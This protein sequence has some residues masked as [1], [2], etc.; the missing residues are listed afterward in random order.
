MEVGDDI[1]ISY[2]GMLGWGCWDEDIEGG[3][4]RLMVGMGWVFMFVGY[5][6]W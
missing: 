3:K 6:L 2:Y 4:C 5:I 1:L